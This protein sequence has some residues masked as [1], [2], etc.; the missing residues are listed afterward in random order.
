M[1]ETQQR[2]NL[3]G[4]FALT[5]EELELAEK[6]PTVVVAVAYVAAVDEE[7][8]DVKAVAVR[9]GCCETDTFARN[10]KGDKR[11]HRLRNARLLDCSPDKRLHSASDADVAAQSK[12]HA[13]GRHNSRH[14]QLDPPCS[15]CRT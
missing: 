1:S 8:E 2:W 9:H 4:T 11:I 3:V 15:Q 6:V 14:E 5:V 7:W 12:R 13:L 10:L